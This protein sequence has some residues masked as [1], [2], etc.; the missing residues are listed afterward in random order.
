[1]LSERI[2]RQIDR[3]L[4]EAEA[5]VAAGGRPQPGRPREIQGCRSRRPSAHS[6]ERGQPRDRLHPVQHSGVTT[7]DL[8]G[9]MWGTE[10]WA[11]R[12]RMASISLE[13]SVWP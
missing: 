7:Q 9:D 11:R 10:P 1:M 13:W 3:F 4:D 8:I 5:A 2:Q 12:L 6:G